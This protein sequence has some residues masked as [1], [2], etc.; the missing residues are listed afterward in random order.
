MLLDLHVQAMMADVVA[1]V[2]DFVAVEPHFVVQVVFSLCL[3]G[4]P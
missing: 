4:S 3:G 1:A 2:V